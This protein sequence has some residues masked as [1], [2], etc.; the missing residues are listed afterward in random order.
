MTKYLTVKQIVNKQGYNTR[1][2]NKKIVKNAMRRVQKIAKTLIEVG[3]DI[4][5]RKRGYLIHESLLNDFLPVYKKR[6]KDVTKGFL[7]KSDWTVFASSV[8]KCKD[9]DKKIL[10]DDMTKLL[11]YLVEKTKLPIKI[12]FVVEYSPKVTN[13][14]HYFI[15]SDYYSFSELREF[16]KENFNNCEN[17]YDH[18]LQFFDKSK[19]E[20]AVNYLHKGKPV[21]R[22]LASDT[23]AEY[24]T[25]NSDGI[26]D[27]PDPNPTVLIESVYLSKGVRK[28]P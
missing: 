9:L 12:F 22:R 27:N 3:K 14:L 15:H 6:I 7:K 13:H 25:I 8:P 2:N 20:G 4:K 18:D 19:Q 28:N 1:Y 16:I 17:I 5:K 11:N 24:T 26:I 21:N 23:S 10:I